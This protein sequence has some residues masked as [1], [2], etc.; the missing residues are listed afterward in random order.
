MAPGGPL[1]GTI[2]RVIG[3]GPGR[4]VGLLFMTLS[5]C[6]I[7]VVLLSFL[8]PRL[9]KVEDELPDAALADPEPEGELR[10]AE[11]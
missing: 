9:R 10:A 6:I 11:A 5:V 3:V 7:V 8:N 1:A 2:G 4:G